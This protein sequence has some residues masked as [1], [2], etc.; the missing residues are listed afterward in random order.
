MCACSQPYSIH[1]KQCVNLKDT[2]IHV[3]PLVIPLHGSAMASLDVFSL[4]VVTVFKVSFLFIYNCHTKY[5]LLWHF[6]SYVLVFFVLI[7]PYYRPYPH[8]FL[9]GVVLKSV[10]RLWAR[11]HADRSLLLESSVGGD[12]LPTERTQRHSRFDL[13]D[14]TYFLIPI[15]ISAP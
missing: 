10:K 15:H 5:W 3:I 9:N 11:G 2:Y 8:F 13:L 14:T 6:H 4:F 7:Q 1:N 12:S